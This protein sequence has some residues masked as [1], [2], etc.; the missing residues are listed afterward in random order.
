MPQVAREFDTCDHGGAPI[1]RD[2]KGINSTVFVNSRAVAVSNGIGDGAT[3]PCGEWRDNLFPPVDLPDTHPLGRSPLYPAGSNPPGIPGPTTGSF[4]VFVGGLPIHRFNDFRG[5][6][7]ETITASPDVWAD[8]VAKI[9]IEGATVNNPKPSPAAITSWGYP[10][11]T[12]F[13][14]TSVNPGMFYVIKNSSKNKLF[15]FL[16]S[17]DFEEWGTSLIPTLEFED[18][19]DADKFKVPD[20][21]LAVRLLPFPLGDPFGVPNITDNPSITTS[22]GGLVAKGFPSFGEIRDLSGFG[23]ISGLGTTENWQDFFAPSYDNPDFPL[24]VTGLAATG[25]G[26]YPFKVANESGSMTSYLKLINIPT[27]PFSNFLF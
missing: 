17:S 11:I 6:G 26:G 12:F 8:F 22:F 3:G 18:I 10:P 15:R 7:A 24:L 4:T 13:Q 16:D 19:T 2:G 21:D 9:R 14:F 27:V 5:C 23:R 20:L 1:G 25:F